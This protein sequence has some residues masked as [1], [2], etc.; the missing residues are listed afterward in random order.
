MA[1]PGALSR[2]RLFAYTGAV[3]AAGVAVGAGGVALG[4][5]TSSAEPASAALVGDEQL[6][7]YGTHQPGIAAPAQ[8]HGWL[9]AF[10]LNS[11]ATLIQ[12]KALL[13]QWTVIA[14]ATMA[15]RSLAAGE[16]AMAYGRGPS[17]LSVTVG[18]GA[19]LLTKLGLGKQI[20][21]QLSPLP[22]F[23]NDALVPASS[24]SSSSSHE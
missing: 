8:T 4:S 3:G 15:G 6:A 19:S 18:V 2:R 16:D 14:A 17:G 11:G 22:K 1:E 7:F 9:T 10:D 24:D 23:L 20:P 21:D 12:V 13:Q 5:G